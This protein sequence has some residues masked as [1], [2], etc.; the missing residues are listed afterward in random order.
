M[1]EPTRVIGVRVTACPYCRRI[2]TSPLCRPWPKICRHCGFT[3]P[4]EEDMQRLATHG[5][6]RGN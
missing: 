3:L 4:P 1:S 5:R 2:V 6:H